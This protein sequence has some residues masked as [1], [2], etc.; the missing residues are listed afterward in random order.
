MSQKTYRRQNFK[1]SIHQYK[2]IG[3]FSFLIEKE[4]CVV[5]P[6]KVVSEITSPCKKEAQENNLLQLHKSTQT[7]CIN[8]WKHPIMLY[9]YQIFI[10]LLKAHK[11]WLCIIMGT[12]ERD[13]QWDCSRNHTWTNNRTPLPEIFILTFLPL[14][15]RLQDYHHFC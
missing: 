1:I 9:G 6:T 5:F 13:K 4:Q 10:F 3:F 12:L 11:P 2:T 8:F 14:Q 7:H 15:L